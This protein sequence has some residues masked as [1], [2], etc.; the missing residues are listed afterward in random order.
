M[1]S[2]FNGVDYI[3]G[4]SDTKP[5]ASKVDDV[6][7]D[8]CTRRAIENLPVLRRQTETRPRKISGIANGH[9]VARVEPTIARCRSALVNQIRLVAHT[10]PAYNGFDAARPLRHGRPTRRPRPPGIRAAI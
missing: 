5:L 10:D 3:F 6:V 2:S 1:L 8:I 4:W 9:T 7:G